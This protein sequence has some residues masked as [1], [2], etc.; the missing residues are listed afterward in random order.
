MSA[1]RSPDAAAAGA[2]PALGDEARGGEDGAA[3]RKNSASCAFCGCNPAAA[4]VQSDIQPA[5]PADA[6][7]W[8]SRPSV[9]VNSGSAASAP[10]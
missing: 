4:A 1:L 9:S 2:G 3:E 8:S 6:E 5:G 7:I 10:T